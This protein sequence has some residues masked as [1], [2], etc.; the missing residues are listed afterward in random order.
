MSKISAEYKETM[1]KEKQMLKSISNRVVDAY[2]TEDFLVIVAISKNH[3]VWEHTFFKPS[4]K[5]DMKLLS[6][7]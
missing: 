4:K 2:E 6:A 1:E 7:N 5:W 3:I